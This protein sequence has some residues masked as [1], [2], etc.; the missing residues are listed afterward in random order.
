MNRTKRA[1]IKCGKQFYGGTDKSYCDECAK[2]IKSNVMRTRTCKLCGAE[3]LGG[4]RASY[5]PN[6]RRIRQR[7]AN[8]RARKRGGATRPIGS[9]DKCKLCGAEYVV[10]TSAKEKRYLHG[11]ENTK[12][13]IIRHPDK[14]LKKQNGG[15]RKRK[16]A[17]IADVFFLLIQQQ[18]HVL[19]I[20]ERKIRK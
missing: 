17:Y 16:S 6:C 20:A 5:C 15:K 4:P 1:C 19:I 13:D 14:T 10:R 7:E 3:F 8:E 12:R 9:I 18:T 11:N 2:A